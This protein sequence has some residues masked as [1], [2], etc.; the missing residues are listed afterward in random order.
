[1]TDWYHQLKKI[2]CSGYKTREANVKKKPQVKT[3]KD[4]K[5]APDLSLRKDQNPC[6][7]E[8]PVEVTNDNAVSVNQ[9]NNYFVDD[10]RLN[11]KPHQTNSSFI[12]N[13]K[14]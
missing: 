14:R 4:K 6:S 12:S 7:P 3:V 13:Q 1:M 8:V 5:P 2:S 9:T 10:L 11:S